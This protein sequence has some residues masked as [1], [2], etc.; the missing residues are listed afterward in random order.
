MVDDIE[1]WEMCEEREGKE[2]RTVGH[3]EATGGILSTFLGQFF[4]CPRNALGIPENPS[5]EEW[6]GVGGCDSVVFQRHPTGNPP[7]IPGGKELKPTL[8]ASK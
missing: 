7:G 1:E 6:G 3:I 4:L 2:G 8:L 5:A